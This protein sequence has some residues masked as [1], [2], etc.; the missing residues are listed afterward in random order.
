MARRTAW[1]AV[2]VLT[3]AGLALRALAAAAGGGLWR[4][5]G[6]ALAVA[7]LPSR[8]EML[9]FLA[10]HES[11]PPLFYAVL[12]AWMAA[13]GHGDAAALAL[14]V[15]LGAAAVPATYAAG[16]RMLSPGA[17]VAAAALVSACP[18]LV[19][20][21]AQVRPYSLLPLLALAGTHALGRALE[22]S[23]RRWW[24]AYAAASLA[25]VL[26]HNW[27]W[28]LLVAQ[29]VVVPLAIARLE[30][31]RR[32]PAL[33]RW[34]ASQAAVALAVAPWAPALARQVA[35][36]GHGPEPAWSLEA[37]ARVIGEAT[38]G[39]PTTAPRATVWIWSLALAAACAW[40]LARLAR[41]PLGSAGEERAGALL[42]AVPALALGGAALASGV[43]Q[44]VLTRTVITVT[45][46][47]ALAAGAAIARRGRRLGPAPA[48]LVTGLVALW[49]ADVGLRGDVK[50]NARELAEAVRAVARPDDLVVV[51]PAWNAGA[52]GRYLGRERP[53]VRMPD[54][55][56]DGPTRYDDVPA[57]LHDVAVL[58]RVKGRLEA[59]RTGGQ[60]VWLVMDRGDVLDVVRT[61][62]LP[63]GA[64]TRSALARI[65]ANQLRH[66]L[67]D[68]YG[69]PRTTLAP[70]AGRRGLE[71]LDAMLFETAGST[72]SDAS[73]ESAAARPMTRTARRTSAAPGSGPAPSR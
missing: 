40:Q 56:G 45:P 70:L 16:A 44:L 43:T 35:H 13:A 11:H 33:G 72:S 17:G 7:E 38:L 64:V 26:T 8:A 29:A 59:A 20:H 65:R 49:T 14:P 67:V 24:A 47:L 27:A 25:S 3:V 15:L 46:C 10:A 21:A 42:L 31:D 23:R 41:A 2:A 68:L 54:D 62:A 22:S 34:L 37:A 48:L 4:V 9:A 12:R 32:G 30:P 55:E 6:T 57:R 28:V 71:M 19:I 69:P 36:A 58:A 66:H 50:S 52:F 61:E 53:V 73:A 51:V 63:R 5:E 18:A 60:R 39:L 1:L